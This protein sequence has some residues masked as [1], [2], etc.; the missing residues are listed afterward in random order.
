MEGPDEG[1]L[2]LHY[3]RPCWDIFVLRGSYDPAWVG[4]AWS[5]WCLPTVSWPGGTADYPLLGQY[6]TSKYVYKSK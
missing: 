2:F 4:H 6:L 5:S 1:Y 3:K